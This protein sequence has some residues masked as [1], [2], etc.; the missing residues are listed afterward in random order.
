[1][2]LSKYLMVLFVFHLLIGEG[3]KLRVEKGRANLVAVAT[4]KTKKTLKVPQRVRRKQANYPKHL[5]HRLNHLS[6]KIPI[7]MRVKIQ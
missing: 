3:G 6:S 1:M 4:L 2:V 7:Q 5:I